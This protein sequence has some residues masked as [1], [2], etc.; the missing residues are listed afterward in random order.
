V[1]LDALYRRTRTEGGEASLSAEGL[2]PVDLWGGAPLPL[3]DW[4]AAADAVQTLQAHTASASDPVRKAFLEDTLVSLATTVDWQAGDELPFR[5][6]AARLLGL[7]IE[8]IADDQLSAWRDQVRE[9]RVSE[10]ARVVPIE[11]LRTVVDRTLAKAH[12]RA[13]ERIG[14]LPPRPLMRL[15]L[16]HDVPYTAYCDYRSNTM[17]LNG[18]Q[19]FTAERLELL[20]LH[21][22][23][24]GHDYHLARRERDVAA[25][26]QPV[27]S[28]LVITNT[29][30]SPLFEGIGDNAPAFLDWP[31]ADFAL[32][33][34]RSAAC[35]NACL[36]LHEAGAPVERVLEYLIEEGLGQPRWA[37]TRLRFMQD[38]LRAPFVFSYYLGYVA[39]ALAHAAW[40]GSPADF[41]ET[42]YGRMHSPRSLRLACGI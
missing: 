2:V 27:D 29:P 4:S 37:E 32:S 21:E 16:V 7:E 24:P 6:R 36:M 18:D 11:E 12:A 20:V 5:E 9:L 34:L 14:P 33:K 3:A 38:A 42:L 31:I 30:S 39:V 17:R 15:E 22:A 19:P 26:R 41:F 13:S 1:S 23:Y 8:P 35:V 25:G 28:L 10:D 40:R